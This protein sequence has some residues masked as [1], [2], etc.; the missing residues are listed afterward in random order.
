MYCCFCCCITFVYFQKLY[1][2]V[3]KKIRYQFHTVIRPFT[4]FQIVAA[5]SFN[6]S[7]KAAI[8]DKLGWTMEELEEV[9]A[10]DVRPCDDLEKGTETHLLDEAWHILYADCISAL[11]V[12]VEGELKHYH[13]ARYMLAQG[14]YKRGETG[15]LEKAKDE[16]SFCFKSSRSSFTINM[17]EI[18][19][20]T[21]RTR[22]YLRFQYMA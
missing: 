22:Y 16:L 20:S 3:S 7:T 21:K 8:L 17:W 4:S 14:L 11:E 19:G 13:K 12:C 6:Q 15:D 18:D 1:F 5:Y 10:K 2:F 9:R